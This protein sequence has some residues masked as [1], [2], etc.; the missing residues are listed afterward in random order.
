MK[1]LMHYIASTLQIEGMSGV[2]HMPVSIMTSVIYVS[3][4]VVFY[5]F[6]IIFLYILL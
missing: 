5:I 1:L 3:V 4:S 2:R 6:L